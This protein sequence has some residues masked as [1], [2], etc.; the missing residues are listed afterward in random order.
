VVFREG[1]M[2][3]KLTT[4]VGEFKGNKTITINNGDRRVITF[5]ITKA[6]AIIESIDAIKEFVA[7]NDNTKNSNDL[8]INLDNLT[9]DQKSLILS[10][11]QR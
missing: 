10:L 7:N 6:K 8:T 11:T 3:S 1:V 2:M 4:V 5:G 9:E